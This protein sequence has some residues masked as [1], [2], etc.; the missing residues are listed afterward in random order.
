MFNRR[1]YYAIK[2]RYLACF[3]TL[4]SSEVLFHCI[5]DVVSGSF[6]LYMSQSEPCSVT[7]D[8]PECQQ[9]DKNRPPA[10]LISYCLRLIEQRA[11]N[12]VKGVHP[13]LM[14]S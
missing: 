7:D 11:S 1:E 3:I 6:M 9:N 13:L 5:C 10:A 2:I 8:K 14:D 12:Y 4:K